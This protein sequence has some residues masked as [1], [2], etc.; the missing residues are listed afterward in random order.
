M[1]PS[2][3]RRSRLRRPSSGSRR[4]RCGSLRRRAS[5][6]RPSESRPTTR[7]SIGRMA[8]PDARRG[9]ADHAVTRRGFATRAIRAA[10]R[11]P[12][13]DQAPTSVPIYQ[14]VTFAAEDAAELG[15]VA[16]RE[17][18]GYAYGRLDNPTV[19]A[20]AAAGAEPERAEAGFP[21]A[22]AMAAV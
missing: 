11:L 13:V 10:H 9:A 12:I 6:P 20:L 14:T 15:A 17:I 1:C 16:T 22:S 19:V 7:C 8:D 3:L 18:P 5:P 4:P 2:P 21:V